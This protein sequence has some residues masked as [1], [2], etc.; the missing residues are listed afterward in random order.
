MVDLTD[1]P[2]HDAFSDTPWIVELTNYVRR[3]HQQKKPIIGICFG[4]QILARALGGRVGRSDA[5]WEVSV[6]SVSLS[7]A[8]K[9]LFSQDTLVRDEYFSAL[10]RS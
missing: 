8:G 9:Q 2:E 6:E 3:I 10:R 7:D 5:G 4:H 1:L